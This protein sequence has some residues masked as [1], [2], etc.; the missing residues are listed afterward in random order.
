MLDNKVPRVSWSIPPI[1]PIP[2]E[3]LYIGATV[4]AGFA[5]A[6]FIKRT[7]KRVT[8]LEH[9]LTPEELLSLEEVGLSI[10]MSEQ[11][12]NQLEWLRDL[13]EDI[14]YTGTSVLSVLNEELMKAKQMYDR[15]FELEP[16]TEPAGMRLKEMLLERIDSV[17]EE[18]DNEMSR[19]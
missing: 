1:P 15:A 18:I 4:T 9:A 14:P 7:K 8:K 3:F 16:P 12:V 5:V 6:I 10:A 13:S 19:R 17:L 2:Q 11:I